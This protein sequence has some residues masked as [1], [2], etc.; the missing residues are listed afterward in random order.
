VFY[1]VG[2]TGAHLIRAFYT[3]PL[4]GWVLA[5]PVNI[6]PGWKGFPGTNTL[7]YL[8]STFERE[9][10]IMIPTS[11]EGQCPESDEDDDQENCNDAKS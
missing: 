8:A 7:A 10:K 4:I 3:T 9:T 2:K 1:L 11:G 6:R 5:S